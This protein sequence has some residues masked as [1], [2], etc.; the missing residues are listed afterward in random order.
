MYIYVCACVSTYELRITSQL[1]LALCD[2]AD[3]KCS[4]KWKRHDPELSLLPSLPLTTQRH[5]THQQQI[6]RMLWQINMFICTSMCKCLR[7]CIST[8][9]DTPTHTATFMLLTMRYCAQQHKIDMLIYT[10]LQI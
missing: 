6:T 1:L 8:F 5:N 10:H 4:I 7:Q 9:M 3:R 2:A